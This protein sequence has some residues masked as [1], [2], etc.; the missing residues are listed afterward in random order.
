M[1]RV[2][3]IGIGN[4]LRGDDGLGWHA[5]QQLRQALPSG[6]FEIV[7]CHQLT[8]ELA[9][10]VA[11]CRRVIFVDAASG[12]PPGEVNQ[13]RLTPKPGP[14]AFSHSFDPAELVQY[15]RELYGRFPEAFAVS[16]NGQTCDYTESLSAP[17]R[18][19]LPAVLRA[20]QDLAC[21]EVPE[22]QEP[23]P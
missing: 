4:P 16:V 8:P 21:E 20:V 7:A 9:E 17:V 2:L 11:R 19:S 15:C 14:S 10:A 5:V 13:Y 23:A 3:I 12:D 18:C 6:R 22:A 1:A